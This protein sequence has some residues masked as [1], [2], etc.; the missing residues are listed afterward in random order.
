VED[1]SEDVRL[2]AATADS[3][4]QS[5][6]VEVS[7]DETARLQDEVHDLRSRVLLVADTLAALSAELRTALR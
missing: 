4:L 6:G 3:V 7:L 1:Q 2:A 5:S